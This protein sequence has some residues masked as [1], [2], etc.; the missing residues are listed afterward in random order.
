MRKQMRKN[1]IKNLDNHILW[2][3]SLVK[4]GKKID[5]DKLTTKKVYSKYF[6]RED[7]V[8]RN[9][10]ETKYIISRLVSKFNLEK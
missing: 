1:K 10:K 8:Q 9:Q 2:L 4:A 5:M 3:E 7:I 6:D